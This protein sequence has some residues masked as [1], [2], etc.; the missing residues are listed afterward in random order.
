MTQLQIRGQLQGSRDLWRSHLNGAFSNAFTHN[1]LI[2][3]KKSN[4]SDVVS[5]KVGKVT[6]SMYIFTLMTIK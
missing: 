4:F 1:M 6:I 5:F 3:P 2:R